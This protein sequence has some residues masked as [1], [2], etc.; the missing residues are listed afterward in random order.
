[1][2]SAC[3]IFFRATC[4]AT[5]IL[6]FCNG[7]YALLLPLVGLTPY[8]SANF[9]E[10]YWGIVTITVNWCLCAAALILYFMGIQY[11]LLLPILWI[12]AH[13]LHMAWVELKNRYRSK[14]QFF[15][16]YFW[17]QKSP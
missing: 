9:H 12:G 11:A 10:G 3:I 5:P 16:N 8:L 17:A 13:W 4:V 15:K 2:R 6:L 7:V 1:M 14:N